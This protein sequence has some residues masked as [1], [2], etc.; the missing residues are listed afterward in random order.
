MTAAVLQRGPDSTDPETESRKNY[1]LKWNNAEWPKWI[2][3]KAGY[4]QELSGACSC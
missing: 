4:R 1:K 2:V 3:L